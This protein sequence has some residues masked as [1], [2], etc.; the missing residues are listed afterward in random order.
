MEQI[1]RDLLKRTIPREWRNMLVPAIGEDAAYLLFMTEGEVRK[2]AD[3]GELLWTRLFDGPEQAALWDEFFSGFAE[4]REMASIPLALSDG[5]ELGNSLWVLL[6]TADGSPTTLG[7]LDARTGGE[8]GFI[9]VDTSS[10]A[11]RF[12]VD[13]D[14]GLLYL[15]L[16]DEAALVV[17]GLDPVPSDWLR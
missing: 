17:V 13:A 2:Y 9:S 10:R 1:Q 6:G 14:R 11:L 12:A 8:R 3:S 15:T 4:T 7:V 5:Q 16:P